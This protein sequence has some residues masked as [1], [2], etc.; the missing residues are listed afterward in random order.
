VEHELFHPI[1]WNRHS[2]DYTLTTLPNSGDYHGA[3]A[4]LELWARLE[5]KILVDYCDGERTNVLKTTPVISWG[6]LLLH[7]F[8]TSE[9]E[10]EPEP[11]RGRGPV[12]EPE[13]GLASVLEWWYSLLCC[14]RN[15]TSWSVRLQL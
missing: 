11:E 4:Q 6:R 13:P 7:C 3:A 14:Q 12:S 9:P 2:T 10:P 5:G 8:V 1:T 15:Q